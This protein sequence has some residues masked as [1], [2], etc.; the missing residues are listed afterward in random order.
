MEKANN[1]IVIIGSGIGGLVC[2]AILTKEGYHVTVVDRNKQIGGNLQTYARDKCIFDS[3]V[4]YVGGL[5]KGQNMYK[6][7]KYLG[8]IDKLKMQK[9][10]E[11]AFDRIVFYDDGK[12]YKYAQG[13][14]KFA[15]TLLS[16]FPGEKEAIDKYC[17][18]LQ[19]ICKSFPLYQLRIGN[20]AAKSSFLEVDTKAFI[21]SLTSNKRL[22]NVLGGNNGLYAGIG[23]K[24][25]IYVHALVLNSYIESS[26]RFVD[27]GSQIAKLLSRIIT[28]G[29]GTIKK[30][31]DIKKIVANQTLVEYIEA[32]DGTK[33]YGDYFISNAH[34]NQTLKMLDSEIIRKAYRNR[35]SGLENSLS[36]FILN[37]TLKPKSF[38][39]Q[40][41]NYYCFLN[42]DVWTS[43]NYTE[44]NWPL[45]YCLFYSASS[46]SEEYAEAITLMAY[47]RYDEVEKWKDTFNTVLHPN[48][49]GEDYEEYKRKKAEKLIDVAEKK[50]PGLRNSII[51]YYSSTPLSFR[52]YLGTED[53]SLYGIAKDYKDPLRTF[54]SPRTKIPNLLLTGQNINLHGVLGVSVSS[55]V[56]CAEIVGIQ[57]LIDKIDHAQTQ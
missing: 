16:D 4:H 29:G 7:F 21:E 1:K 42:D 33:F 36:A 47:M 22:Q 6:I 48:S 13:Y 23:D 52:D 56:T 51:G 57:N 2:G 39:Y 55:V 27:G 9:L 14:D 11:E 18:T 49:R 26:Y 41:T 35:I 19:S 24:T 25:P 15:A 38:K 53:G 5:D 30:H 32:A 40:K 50:F 34:P 43:M 44:E 3:G 8:I 45:S 31:T 54:I 20:Y 28:G 12:E 10:D 17:E 46:K 37:I